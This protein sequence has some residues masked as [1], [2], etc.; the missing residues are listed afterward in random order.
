MLLLMP[1][2]PV[3]AQ[4][5]LW[6][7]PNGNDANVCSQTAPCLT[8]QGAVLKGNVAQINCL[9]SGNYG[10]VTIT[11]S[12]TID[13]GTGNVGNI[14]VPGNTNAI[15]INTPTAATIVLR[16]LSLNGLHNPNGIYG[17]NTVAFSSGTLVVEDCT[18]QGF[19]HGF[20]IAFF[21]TA[22]RGLLQVSNSQIIDNIGGITVQPSNGQIASATL[23]RVAMVANSTYGLVLSG[24][25]VIAGTMRESIA[26]ENAY[27]VF[28]DATQAFF[29][30]EESSVIAN[31]TA[32][33]HTQSGGAVLNVG[34]STI[35]A[36]LVGVDPQAG[37]IISFGNNQFSA[38][39][40][41]GNFTG[42]KA[43]K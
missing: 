13:C 3:Q 14:D 15:T 33:I 29:T 24:S 16:H 10:I 9:S 40:A 20:G 18:I 23:S 31:T 41:D 43:L 11:A 22:G 35:G 37:S 39:A 25:G 1:A 7:A 2:S 17:I 34:S 38:N 4:A 30:I 42:T 36:N 27:G 5:V 26:G 32:G 19:T 21:P 6:V 8:F 28:V 12:I